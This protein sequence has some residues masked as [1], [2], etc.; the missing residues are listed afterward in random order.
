MSHFS[1]RFD[2]PLWSRRQLLLGVGFAVSGLLAWW[3]LQSLPD[4]A[5]ALKARA[6][7][8]DYVV[9]NFVALETDA[10]GKPSRRLAASELRHFVDENLSELD[11]PRMELL[12]SDGPAWNAVAQTG[13]VLAGGDQVRLLGD[14]QLDRKGDG[15]IRPAHLETAR[16]DLWRLQSLAETDLPVRIFSDGDS[17]TANGM[18]LWYA[19]HTR[20]TF[21]GRARLQL[22]PESPP[23]SRPPPEPN[24]EAPP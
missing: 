16:I 23:E 19:D 20:T 12:Q 17:L 15:H 13:L 14:V 21:H 11:H 2:R 5:R 1:S 18:R 10:T 9:L 8:P 3:R 4:E 7:L 24:Q 6:R 22:A